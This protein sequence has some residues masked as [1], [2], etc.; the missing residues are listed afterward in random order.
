[1]EGT[2][3]RGVEPGDLSEVCMVLDC[4]GQIILSAIRLAKGSD[5]YDPLRRCSDV[6]QGKWT[7]ALLG[8][9]RQIC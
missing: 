5:E 3:S 9:I 1:M 8:K 2:T 4:K 7:Y 6:R